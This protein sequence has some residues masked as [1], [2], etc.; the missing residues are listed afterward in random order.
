MRQ[1]TLVLMCVVAALL[2]ISA[3][4]KKVESV[5]EDLLVKVIVDGQWAVT[6]YTQGSNDLTAIFSPYSFQ[7]KKDFTVDAINNN[8]VEKTGTWNGSI[9]TKTITSNFPDPNPILQ[10]LNGNWLITDSGLTY[11]ES[12]QTINGNACFLRLV[13]K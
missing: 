10:L 6:K 3:C 7:F 11:V 9:A 8:A 2:S 4:K 5:K 1:T 12:T 13:K